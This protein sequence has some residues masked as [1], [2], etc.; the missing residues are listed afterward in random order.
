MVIVRTQ[1][2][3]YIARLTAH[4]DPARPMSESLAITE[5]S[6]HS[7]GEGKSDAETQ[8]LDVE[9]TGGNGVILPETNSSGKSTESSSMAEVT[10]SI[11]C[12]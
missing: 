5:L 2:S 1:Y 9:Q 7:S 10:A 11:P 12:Q 8:A 6:S 3:D 4:G